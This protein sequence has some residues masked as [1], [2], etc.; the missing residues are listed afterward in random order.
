VSRRPAVRPGYTPPRVRWA[1]V[2]PKTSDAEDAIFL[3]S[4]YGLIPDGWQEPILRDWVSRRANGKW[5]YGKCGLAVPRQNGKNGVIEM[6]ELWGMVELGEAFLHAAHEVKTTR[7]AFKRLKHFFGSKADDPDA[8]FPELNALV[9]EVRS[10]NGQEAIFLKDVY[11]EDGRWVRKGGSIEFV[12][13]SNGSGRGYTVDVL[14]LDEA[15]HLDD[16]ELEAIRSAVSSAPL[17]NPQ[18][19]YAGTP[20]DRDK[21][22]LGVVWIRIRSGAGKDKRLCWTEYGAP[23]GPMPDI[24]DI[25]LLYATNPALELRHGN[26]AFGL[27]MDVVRD[28]RGDLSEQGYARERYGWWGNPN[29]RRRGVLDMDRWGQLKVAGDSIPTRGLIV[30]DCSPDLEWTSIGLAADGPTGKVLVLVNRIE[31][32]VGAV[33]RVLELQ[34]DLGEVLEVALTPQAKLLSAKLTKAGVEHKLLTSADVGAGCTAFQVMVKQGTAVHVGQQELNDAVQNA[35]TRYVAGVQV[36]DRRDVS[37]DISALVSGS[38]AAQRYALMTAK[39]DAPPP[40]PESLDGNDDLAVTRHS[41]GAA[42]MAW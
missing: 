17:G 20:P 15:Q 33:G 38:T 4:A 21:G 23:D 41:A 19:I 35:I 29:V 16:D 39:P 10:T 7:K 36:W 13:R 8:K 1:P 31:G 22:E 28:E 3:C 40:S 6:R 9:A 5:C 30:V 18:V 27:T 25:D 24:D 42:Q 32:T 14:V 34:E 11:D 26:G 12:A 2:K 37:V